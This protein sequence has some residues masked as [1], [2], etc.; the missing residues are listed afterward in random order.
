MG[1]SAP[2]AAL[3]P[4]APIPPQTPVQV[5]GDNVGDRTPTEVLAEREREKQAVVT[6]PDTEPT[7]SRILPVSLVDT[8]TAGRKEERRIAGQGGRKKTRVTGPQGLLTQA[9]VKKRGLL[10]T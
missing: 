4:P 1:K 10:G 7:P 9:P 5:V 6:S 3:P 2:Q 8:E